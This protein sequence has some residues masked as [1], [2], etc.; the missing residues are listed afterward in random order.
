MTNQREAA[1]SLAGR[2][3]LIEGR[4]RCGA[5]QYQVNLPWP[6]LTYAC[7]CT[8]C[9]RAT[10]S[11]FAL[12]MPVPRTA[13]QVTGE[14]V[15][16]KVSGRDSGRTVHQHC[17]RCLIGLY[18]TSVSRPALVIIRAGTVDG[19]D[20]IAPLLHLY[21][22]TKLPWLVLP[23]EVP[24]FLHDPTPEEFSKIWSRSTP[25][26]GTSRSGSGVDCHSRAVER[27]AARS[28]KPT[29]PL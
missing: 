29:L 21:I 10:G 8:R 18:G 3:A 7:H 27:C 6:P 20:R 25:R 16:A 9:Q 14:L 11:A 12:Q 5:V 28:G 24:S 22:S 26:P 15:V 13:L 1:V 17:A 2:D 23:S 4:C 19:S